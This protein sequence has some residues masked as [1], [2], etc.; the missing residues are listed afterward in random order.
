MVDGL[1][2]QS[3]ADF[4]KVLEHLRTE[5]SRLQIGRA[6]PAL[7]ES[8]MIDSYGSKQHLKN[9]ASIS[10]PDPKTIQIQPWDKSQ[11]A[12]IEKGIQASDLNLNPLNDGVVIRVVLPPLTEERRKDLSKVVHKL[13]E[14]ARITV[15]NIRQKAHDKLKEAEKNGDITEDLQRSGEKRLQE[16]VDATNTE[17]ET[18]AKNK[19]KDILTV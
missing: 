8:L 9:L 4:K 11:L 17:I 13:A 7:V 10:I 16:K 2:Q 15:R 5:Y 6:S 12:A 14:E 1:L 3:D 18:T 19:E